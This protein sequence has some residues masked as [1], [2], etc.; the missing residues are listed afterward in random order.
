MVRSRYV[1]EPA[2]LTQVSG[3]RML[4]DE[5]L[6]AAIMR[7]LSSVALAGLANG[8][9]IDLSPGRYS[10]MF[11]NDAPSLVS[12]GA[13]YAGREVLRCAERPTSP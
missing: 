8:V 1:P 3:A 4:E 11:N 6:H 5:F 10:V 12:I 13:E 7:A 2:G 9:G